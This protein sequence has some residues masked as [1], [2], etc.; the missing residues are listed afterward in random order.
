MIDPLMQV[1]EGAG[2]MNLESGAHLPVQYAAPLLKKTD[3]SE[4]ISPAHCKSSASHAG[5]ELSSLAAHKVVAAFPLPPP[6]PAPA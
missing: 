3:M 1:L 6:K 4:P 2:W 5:L